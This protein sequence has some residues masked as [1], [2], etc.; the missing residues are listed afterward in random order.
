M[1]RPSALDQSGTVLQ[2]LV[3]TAVGFLGA[4]TGRSGSEDT[5]DLRLFGSCWSGAYI[6]GGLGFKKGIKTDNTDSTA[7]TPWTGLAFGGFFRCSNWN[8]SR[9]F[10]FKHKTERN[11]MPSAFTQ[12]NRRKGVS[13]P[14]LTPS[15]FSY[16]WYLS[17]SSS[18]EFTW[19]QLLWPYLS[20]FPRLLL[21]MF[22]HHLVLC[23]SRMWIWFGNLQ[24][25]RRTIFSQSFTE[26][27]YFSH[28]PKVTHH[29]SLF[30]CSPR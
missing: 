28:G 27:L 1:A 10:D 7:S 21:E 11:P 24:L 26:T 22:P 14:S 12:Q 5:P 4:V 15:S 9:F 19:T 30:V 20:Y 2:A 29:A 17:T 6:Y 23:I 16:L 13:K 8:P 3:S 18:T 25:G